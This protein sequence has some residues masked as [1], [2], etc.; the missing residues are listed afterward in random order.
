VVRQHELPEET[1]NNRNRGDVVKKSLM[2]HAAE[3]LKFTPKENKAAAVP[4][5]RGAR[6]TRESRQ[7]TLWRRDFL[8]H[9]DVARTTSRKEKNLLLHDRRWGRET[10]GRRCIL[11]V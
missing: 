5:E 7:T 11:S 6:N 8:I 4:T 1:E 10:E 2:R 3:L 9:N